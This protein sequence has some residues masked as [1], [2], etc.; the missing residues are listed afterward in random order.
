MRYIAHNVAQ[1][2]VASASWFWRGLLLLYR[3]SE[4]YSDGRAKLNRFYN[5]AKTKYL[6][7]Y[8]NYY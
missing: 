6:I 1:L 2:D 4:K 3:L 7:A 5:D 8:I